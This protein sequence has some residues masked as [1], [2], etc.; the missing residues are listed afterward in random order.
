VND[1]KTDSV[2]VGINA[3]SVVLDKQDKVWVLSAGDQANAKVAKLSRINP[4][5]HQIELSLNFVSGSPGNLCLNKTKDTLYYL[6][7]DVY[8]MAITETA[9]PTQALI[10]KGNK[11][12]YGLGINPNDYSIYVADALDYSQ[13]SNI[14]IYSS[15]GEQKFFFKAGIIA[16][17]FYFE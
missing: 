11:N 14:Y 13:K 5:N 2:E 15:T 1:T 16:N 17:S 3:A 6:N 4:V 8:R 12:F 7:G 9:L 10:S